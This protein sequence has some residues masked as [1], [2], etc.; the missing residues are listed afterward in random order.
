MRTLGIR[1]HGASCS[2]RQGTWRYR[3]D[4]SR[5]ED[6]AYAGFTFTWIAAFVAHYLA[7]DGL[8]AYEPLIL[9]GFLAVS[10]LSRPESRQR[11]VK[12]TT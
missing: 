4:R 3:I 1:S 8:I 7:N 11:P 6:W 12:V 2:G 10:Y 9:L 5:L